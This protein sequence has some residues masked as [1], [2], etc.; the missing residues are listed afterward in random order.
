M[1]IGTILGAVAG[2]IASA[3]ASKLFGG[4]KKSSSG[5]GK[6]D[7]VNVDAGGLRSTLSNGRINVESSGLRRGLVGDIAKTFPEQA[8]FFGDLASRVAPGVSEL[9]RSR[10]AEIESA[11]SRS[12]G[13]LR[14][15]LQRRRVLGSSFG[16]DAI[17]RADAE[18]AKESERVAAESFLTEVEL[19]TQLRMAEFEARRGEFQTHLDEMNLQA[20]LAS[21]LA[22]GATSQLGANARLKA[23]LDAEAA[24]GAGRFFGSTIG[25][26]VQNAVSSI[27]TPQQI[28]MDTGGLY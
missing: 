22:T 19:S 11:R 24:A 16:Q 15:N 14:E 2:G 12:V 10:L 23:Q 13:N 9:R 3:G 8:R 7:I 6:K 18:F 17:A 4:S 26:A 5:G 27:F 1:A 28:V 21:Q 25:P 20:D